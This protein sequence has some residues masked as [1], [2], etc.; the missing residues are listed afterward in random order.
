MC[1]DNSYNAQRFEHRIRW[2]LGDDISEYYPTYHRVSGTPDWPVIMRDTVA[3]QNTQTLAHWGLIPFWTKTKLDG[4]KSSNAMVNAR[5]ETIHEKT[6]YKNL[7]YKSRCILPSTGFFEHHHIMRGKKDVSIP[8]YIRRQDME[9]FGLGAIY[10]TWTD[11]TSGE[12]ITSF[13]VITQPANALMEKIHNHGDN[14]HR[15]PLIL[16]PD[17]EAAWMDPASHKATVDEI[18]S[19]SIPADKLHAW[20]VQSVR[21]RDRPDSAELW[22]KVEVPEITWC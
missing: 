15:M 11:K 22:E 6:A 1:R 10:T 3:G 4:I 7:I 2:Q 8:F 12:V 19:Y 20:P 9:I 21:R 16:E 17:M 5:R 14:A 18:M 13:S